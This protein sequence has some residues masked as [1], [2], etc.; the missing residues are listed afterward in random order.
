LRRSIEPVPPTWP[1]AR[2]G[3][4]ML[5]AGETDLRAEA[6]VGEVVRLYL[7][8]TANTRIF[9]IAM[10][11]MSTVMWFSPLAAM[12]SSRARPREVAAR[13]QAVPRSGGWWRHP[14]SGGGVGAADAVAF[15]DEHVGVVQ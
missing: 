10:T 13:G 7:A 3:N 8:N 4:V 9:N 1:W 12:G 6:R 14:L 5:T 2:F 15:G 11:A